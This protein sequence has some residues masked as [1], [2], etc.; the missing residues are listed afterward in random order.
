LESAKLLVSIAGREGE[1]SVPGRY[2][3]YDPATGAL[4]FDLEA[5]NR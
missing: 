3:I 4:S 1:L 2:A 5:F